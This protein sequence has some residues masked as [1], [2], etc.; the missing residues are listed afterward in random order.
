MVL[1][2]V[3]TSFTHLST[4]FQNECFLSNVTLICKMKIRA[5]YCIANHIKTL[6]Q[7]LI[8]TYV[9]HPRATYLFEIKI[10]CCASVNVKL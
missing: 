5:V 1:F 8:F 2:I 6:N 9:H 4:G 10:A 3:E 7:R